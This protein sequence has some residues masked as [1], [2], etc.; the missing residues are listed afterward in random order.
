MQNKGAWVFQSPFYVR[1]SETRGRS[2]SVRSQLRFYGDG[3]FVGFAMNA[4]SAVNLDNGGALLCDASLY[5]I[6]TEYDPRIARAF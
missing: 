2:P 6:R 3:N 4:E 1:N 5:P